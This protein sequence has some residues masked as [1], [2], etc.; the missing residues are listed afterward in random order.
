MAVL[1]NTD[2]TD[3][4]NYDSYQ[5]TTEMLCANVAGGGK[6]PCQGDSG[7]SVVFIR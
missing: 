2:C 3:N 1:T 5:I 7:L 4:Y 6:D